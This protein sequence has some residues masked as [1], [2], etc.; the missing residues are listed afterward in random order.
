MASIQFR[1]SLAAFL[2]MLGLLIGQE[3]SD[4]VK[5]AMPAPKATAVVSRH[6]IQRPEPELFRLQKEMLDVEEKKLRSEYLPNLS[7]FF[8]GAWG[9][10]GRA[11]CRERGCQYE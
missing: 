5:L 2:R 7:A 4:S 6:D 8:Q 10:I 3:L 1:S 11:S 9:K